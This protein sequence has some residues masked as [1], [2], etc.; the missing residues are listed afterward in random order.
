MVDHLRDRYRA[1]ERHACRILL[2]V[3]GTYRYRSHREGW[4]ELRMRIREIA[5]G[6]TQNA[7]NATESDGKRRMLRQAVL[8]IGPHRRVAADNTYGNGELLQWLDDRGITPYIRVKE[9]PAGKSDL[10]GIE[11]FTYLPEQNCY[12]CPE[13]N[14]L[15]HRVRQYQWRD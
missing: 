10:Y 3:R 8:I 15:Q 11:K 7:T 14:A 4:A 5:A 6:R 13:G 12:V 2:M 1:S 9:S